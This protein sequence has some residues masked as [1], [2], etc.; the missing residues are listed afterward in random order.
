MKSAFHFST[1]L[2]AHVSV[3]YLIQENKEEMSEWRKNRRQSHGFLW[4][5]NDVCFLLKM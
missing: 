3:Y 2:G 5:K 1:P 4:G